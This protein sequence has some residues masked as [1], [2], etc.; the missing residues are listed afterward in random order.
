[1]PPRKESVIL[2]HDETESVLDTLFPVTDYIQP[3]TRVSFSYII[4]DSRR[5]ASPM[6]PRLQ[7]PSYQAITQRSHRCSV[8]RTSLGRVPLSLSSLALMNPTG[9]GKDP[10]ILLRLG[11]VRDD[12]ETVPVDESNGVAIHDVAVHVPRKMH[13][14]TRSIV[15]KR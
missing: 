9:N 8:M 6:G 7:H 15:A 3:S 2:V 4:Q 5:L 1:M 13:G 14:H 11:L 10:N 12:N